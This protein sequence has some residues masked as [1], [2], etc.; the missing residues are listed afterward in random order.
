MNEV[1][2]FKYEDI[3]DDLKSVTRRNLRTRPK[4]L[5]NLLGHQINQSE[6]KASQKKYV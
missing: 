2:D 4:I 5:K 1:F 6:R 3:V